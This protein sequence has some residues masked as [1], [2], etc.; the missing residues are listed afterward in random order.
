M[1][2]PQ[3]KTGFSKEAIVRF[4]WAGIFGVGNC[5]TCSDE[6]GSYEIAGFVTR[7]TRHPAFHI[8]LLEILCTLI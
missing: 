1:S 3:L 8:A 2:H 7:D 4:W 6:A 5:E